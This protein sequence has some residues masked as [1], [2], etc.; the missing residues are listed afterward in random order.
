MNVL[1]HQQRVVFIHQ[2]IFEMSRGNFNRRIPLSTADDE[3]ETVAVLLNLA[4]EELG[5]SI[6]QAGFVNIHK[7]PSS[8]SQTTFILNDTAFITD[9]SAEAGI[10][11]DYIATDLLDVSLAQILS[12][13]SWKQFRLALD[14]PLEQPVLLLLDF[15]NS[16][17]LLFSVSC[18]LG[19]FVKSGTLV[20]KLLNPLRKASYTLGAFKN[21]E[22]VNY[23][24][25]SAEA[26]LMQKVYDYVLAHLDE[27]LPPLPAL[28]RT[29]GTNEHKLKQGFRHF[30]DTSIY[31]FYNKHRL[32]RASFTIETT[33]LPLK[34][35]SEMS[36]FTNYPNFSKAFKKQ[37]KCSPNQVKRL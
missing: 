28:S 11:L 26:S 1:Q 37:F 14:S 35:I 34:I 20:L 32:E 13:Q 6:F 2:M 22:K 29:F 33:T 19:R 5:E 36:G 15:M 7:S 27:P 25:R 17:Q 3:L 24:S 30:F 10:F 18:T 23:R 8:F 12:A 21:T 16:E 9:V 4:A 31:Q